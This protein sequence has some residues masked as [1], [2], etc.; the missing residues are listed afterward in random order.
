MLDDW[1]VWSSDDSQSA[2]EHAEQR[3]P[4]SDVT[5]LKFPLRA[6]KRTKDAMRVVQVILSQS[7]L[8]QDDL[9]DLSDARK[10]ELKEYAHN[11]L[12]TA[13]KDKGLVSSQVTWGDFKGTPALRMEFLIHPKGQPESANNTFIIY[14]KS[15]TIKISTVNI[16]LNGKPDHKKVES[17]II[18]FKVLA[19]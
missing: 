17:E 1:E 6:E 14:R 11:D 18:A 4:S 2:T 19:Q 7:E 15:T 16:E 12:K 10:E 3:S 8:T 9:I 5:G 13:M